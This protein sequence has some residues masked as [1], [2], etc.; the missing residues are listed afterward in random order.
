MVPEISIPQFSK[1]N[2]IM[3]LFHDKYAAI[4]HILAP[5]KIPLQ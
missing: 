2:A 5:W 4:E 3:Y 1:T